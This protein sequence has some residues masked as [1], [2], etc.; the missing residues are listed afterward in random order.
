M[1]STFKLPDDVKE[2]C[3][4]YSDKLRAQTRIWASAVTV[5]VLVILNYDANSDA[6]ALP[7]GLGSAA[8]VPYFAITTWILS[9]LWFGQLIQYSQSVRAY[10]I[11]RARIESYPEAEV[12]HGLLL[13]DHYG[14]FHASGPAHLEPLLEGWSP[15]V[16]KWRWLRFPLKIIISLVTQAIPPFAICVGFARLLQ[17]GADS[18]IIGMVAI[19]STIVVVS[20]LL[21]FVLLE[22]PNFYTKRGR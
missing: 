2:A 3:D 13:A 9:G 11:I 1:S 7:F 14:I 22:V 12:A 16:A 4:T 19:P 21:N 5:A 8:P 10:K 18:W 6:I 20:T 17:L 15:N